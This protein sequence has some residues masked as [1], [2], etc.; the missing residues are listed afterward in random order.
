MQNHLRRLPLTALLLLLPV[1]ACP[2]IDDTGFTGFVDGG[3]DAG[4]P[5]PPPPPK[6]PL[7][8]GDELRFPA[9]GGRIEPCTGGAEGSCERTMV[10]TY[11]VNSVDLDEDTNKWARDADFVYE[12][13]VGNIDSG[14]MAQLFLSNVAPFGQLEPGT[15]ESD[16]AT[17]S[18]DAAPTD[19]IR[20]DRFPFFH[21]EQEYATQ[22]DSAYR[23]ASAEFAERIREIDADAQIENQAAEAKMEAYFR[24]D[25]GANTFLHKIRI[26]YHP[27][28]FICGWEERMVTWSDDMDRNEGDFAGLTIPIAAVW[29][30]PVQ[31][32]RDD[33]RYNCTCGAR[34][35]FDRSDRNTCL[36][37]RDPDADP[38]PC[39]CLNPDT[40]PDTCP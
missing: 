13:A 17:F 24:D 40:A 27:F 35:C 18:T 31:L 4:P 9:V 37:P 29:V 34:E 16:T 8:E 15:S 14:A 30:D 22:D 23:L 12:L 33:V 7:K 39:E 11:V 32:I 3:V 38:L 21:F 5:P 26:D 2:C 6:F 28:G 20:E 10:A 1:S 36:D 19:S 25:L